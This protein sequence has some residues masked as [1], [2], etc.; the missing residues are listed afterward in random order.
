MALGT[1]SIQAASQSSGNFAVNASGS[2]A[3]DLTVQGEAHFSGG[4]DFGTTGIQLSDGTLLRNAASIR[5]S[6]LFTTYGAIAATV[7]ASGKVSFPYGITMGA[8]NVTAGWNAISRGY[9]AS[10][11]GTTASVLG[12]TAFGYQTVA[13]GVTS[14]AIGDR[15]SAP[16]YDSFVLGRFNISQGDPSKWVATDDLFVVGNGASED[17]RANAF[18]VK[19]NGDAVLNG[20]LCIPPK[21]DLSMGGFTAE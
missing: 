15:T 19:K 5:S 16:S 1:H 2:E 6:G 21:G 11:A 7:D 10:A 18:V 17:A 9:K 4:I 13:D 20:A 12:S 8:S 3:G 14:T